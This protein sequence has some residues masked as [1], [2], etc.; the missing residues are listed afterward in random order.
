[1]EPMPADNLVDLLDQLRDITEPPPI[2]M[3][4]ATWAWAVLA[5]LLLAGLALGAV[6]FVRHRRAT[7][8]RRAALAE[9]RGLAPELAAGDPVALARLQTLLRRV[10][11][12]TAE[13]AEAAPLAGDAWAGFLE[14]TGGDFGALGAALAAAPY[15]PAPAYDGGAAISAARRWICRQ[16]A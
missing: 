7:A 8:W 15:R 2:P 4:P 10:A 14:R 9:L 16:H 5:A 3:W 1:M 6:A 12:V 13:R 11:L